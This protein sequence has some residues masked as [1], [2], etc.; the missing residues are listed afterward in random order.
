MATFGALGKTAKRRTIR[1]G[2]LAK[3]YDTTTGKLFESVDVA[4]D[5]NDT[6]SS[7]G[8]MRLAATGDLSDEMI[9]Q[10]AAGFS[11]K[12]ANR[13]VEVF[14][15]ARVIGLTGAEVMINRG[16]KSSIAVGQKWGVYGLG[17]EMIDPDTGESLG[18][19]ESKVGVVEVVRVTPRFSSAKI[20]E[21]FGIQKLHVLRKEETK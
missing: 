14:F 15:P 18:R 12:V 8:A 17:E 16:D 4:Y 9:R 11:D 2:C 13:V 20:L 1:I 3:I 6:K 19:T 21:N 7:G 5:T 10:M